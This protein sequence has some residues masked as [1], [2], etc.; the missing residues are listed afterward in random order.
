MGLVFFF[1][2]LLF[3]WHL[4]CTFSF[5]VF[6]FPFNFFFTFFYQFARASLIFFFDTSFA[7]FH[8][9]PVMIFV[10]SCVLWPVSLGFFLHVLG[11]IVLNVFFQVIKVI[12]GNCT[13]KS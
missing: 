2:L 7:P 9:A 6:I 13:P 3:L 8:I 1:I 11:N 5:A 4:A 12:K 10:V